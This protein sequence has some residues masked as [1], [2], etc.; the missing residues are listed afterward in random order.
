MNRIVKALMKVYVFLFIKTRRIKWPVES[1]DEYDCDMQTFKKKIMEFPYK[2]DPLGGFIDYV[3]E[4]DDFWKKDRTYGRDC[5]DWARM[6]SIW[7]VYHG[8][9]A[10]EWIVCN[11]KKLF[12][13][14]HVITVL[15]KNGEW[16]LMNYYAYGPFSS[17]KDALN[18][19]E[20]FSEYKGN[21]ISVR[22]V[23]LQEEGK[24]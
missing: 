10:T 18:M 13:T 8:F 14:M 9:I 24:K 1:R 15:E 16:Y 4:P 11:P 21:I 12:K 22:S 7:G 2:S 17:E 19:M 5:D 23:T 6:W 3:A 20:R